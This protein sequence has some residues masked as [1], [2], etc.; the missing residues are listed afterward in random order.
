MRLSK[1]YWRQV[2][3]PK[4]V[5]TT[6]FRWTNRRKKKG[7]TFCNSNNLFLLSMKWQSRQSINDIQSAY[8]HPPSPL[9]KVCLLDTGESKESKLR[10]M[11]SKWS[12]KHTKCILIQPNFLNFPWGAGPQTNPKISSLWCL[13]ICA[14]GPQTH[15]LHYKLSMGLQRCLSQRYLFVW[16][17]KIQNRLQMAEVV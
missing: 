16:R 1:G 6:L 2:T 17:W 4:N 10:K 9:H 11:P 12:S 7:V 14:L 5:A 3:L 15:P 13:S 8:A